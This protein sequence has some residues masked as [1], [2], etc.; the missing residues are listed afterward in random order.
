MAP[1]KHYLRRA[2]VKPPSSDASGGALIAY[3]TALRKSVPASPHFNDSPM[4]KD[5]FDD[6]TAVTERYKKAL[7][8]YAAILRAKIPSQSA[9]LALR[10]RYWAQG[11]FFF[12]A[13]EAALLDDRPGIQSFGLQLHADAGPPPVA[14]APVKLRVC[15]IKGQPGKY[16]V[17]WNRAPGAGIYELQQSPDHALD[18]TFATAYTGKDAKAVGKG[19]VGQVLWFRVRAQGN[20]TSAWSEP[21][22]YLVV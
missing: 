22:R 7:I 13:V 12:S 2:R 6:W 19:R 20:Q 16:T 15:P 1:R 9:I 4:I 8:A 18:D 3:Q 17:R 14:T 5:V 10:A 11:R 21:V